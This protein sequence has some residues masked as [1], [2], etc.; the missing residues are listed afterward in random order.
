MSYISCLSIYNDSEVFGF[1]YGSL[2]LD[3]TADIWIEKL[4]DEIYLTGNTNQSLYGPNIGAQDIFISKHNNYNG[5]ILWKLQYG[6]KLPE[7]GVS[8]TSSEHGVYVVG[9]TTGYMYENY[10]STISYYSYELKNS[11]EVLS[12]DIFLCQ[13][14]RFE[15]TVCSYYFG[16]ST[17]YPFFELYDSSNKLVA[18]TFSGTCKSSMIFLH[19]KS[20]CES[21]SIKFGCSY[22]ACSARVA[23]IIYS[24]PPAVPVNAVDTF[25]S[26]HDPLTG[27]LL[28][29]YQSGSLGF[30]APA[31]V[32]YSQIEDCIYVVGY[33]QGYF[34]LHVSNDLYIFK[35]NSTSGKI[36]WDY[37]NGTV[38]D[39]EGVSL[40]ID[41][42]SGTLYVLGATRGNWFSSINGVQDI[43]LLCMSSNSEVMWG[44]QFGSGATDYPTDI[45]MG[46]DGSLYLCGYSIRYNYDSSFLY[47]INS[48]NGEIIWIKVRSSEY[49]WQLSVSNSSIFTLATKNRNY[50]VYKSDYLSSDTI[51]S[52]KI[53]SV[54]SSF[55]PWEMVRG[56]IAIS[57]LGTPLIGGS[58]E[59]N[60]YTQS[61][62]LVDYYLLSPQI[63][64]AG[65]YSE[66][67]ISECVECPQNAYS[68]S[69]SCK[70]NRCP[71]GQYSESG[72]A[73]CKKCYG[74]Y[75]HNHHSEC[76]HTSSHFLLYSLAFITPFMIVTSC[77]LLSS[78]SGYGYTLTALLST[79]DFLSDLLYLTT[80]FFYNSALFYLSIAF[81]FPPIIELIY[82]I[83]RKVFKTNSQL[84][85]FHL[86]TLHPAIN[87]ILGIF[88]FIPYFFLIFLLGY[89]LI[90][91]K[92]LSLPFYI[93]L[94]HDLLFVTSTNDVRV[95]EVALSSHSTDTNSLPSKSSPDLRVNQVNLHTLNKA[96]L[97]EI[98]FEAIPQIVIQTIN[99]TR[100]NSFGTISLISLVISVL[101]ICNTL[102]RLLYYY[103]YHGVPLGE[104][105]IAMKTPNQLIPETWLQRDTP[106]EDSL[107]TV[108]LTSDTD[109]QMTSKLMNVPS[110]PTNSLLIQLD[111]GPH[112]L[113]FKTVNR[114]GNKTLEV[115]LIDPSFARNHPTL[116]RG[117]TVESINGISVHESPISLTSGYC[118]H[119]CTVSF[120]SPVS[121]YKTLSLPSSCLFGSELT[122][123][124][125]S[126]SFSD[127][128]FCSVKS[129]LPDSPIWGDVSLL[130]N[131][132]SI[133]SLH[134]FH[135]MCELINSEYEQENP[136][137]L[138]VVFFNH[139]DW[140]SFFVDLEL[141]SNHLRDCGI[142]NSC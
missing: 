82:E 100:M 44:I 35:V 67:Y 4:S 73:H 120:I 41:D 119:P 10:S 106:V 66:K 84:R 142:S 1:Q 26:C 52:A 74:G 24:Y 20:T 98:Y 59:L 133:N 112:G 97:I 32:V 121:Q 91:T 129:I 102:Y 134:Y 70:C 87:I 114:F 108:L 68:H 18:S 110:T 11:K 77:L 131:L 62:G 78:W 126:T 36:I 136:E 50:V 8:V 45:E 109:E 31:K 141:L 88:L 96:I 37:L 71:R 101:I 38:L 122:I 81:L 54:P 137:L 105:P 125:H 47:K 22:S 56:S 111:K 48:Q 46:G 104:I 43:V 2:G 39:D 33:A 132:V 21:Y 57:S 90:Q 6:S 115:L 13:G 117:Y 28:W 65:F 19:T 89:Y 16:T 3:Y 23:L 12:E 40:T 95:S 58:T 116:L 93:E 64:V 27:S 53:T 9:Y 99:N 72:S 135:R 79:A 51:W 118:S 85:I 127:V 61:H 107:R 29:N 5:E 69:A 76:F 113:T 128:Y 7:S 140:S 94:W 63:C 60:L 130:D 17:K 15:A 55:I 92:L 86:T 14:Q 34:S 42:Q 138:E 30:D 139:S 25:M 75:Y 103:F 80:T 123:C 49:S 83:G 124:G